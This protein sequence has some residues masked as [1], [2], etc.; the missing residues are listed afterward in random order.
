MPTSVIG[1]E[2]GR[3]FQEQTEPPK[4]R[5]H[6]G[7]NMQLGGAPRCRRGGVAFRSV[8]ET[9]GCK[10]ERNRIFTVS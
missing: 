1:K 3:G 2:G 8:L 5:G 9:T 4:G 7:R 10:F 6:T